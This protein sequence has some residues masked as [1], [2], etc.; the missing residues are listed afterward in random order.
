VT[1]L[2][3]QAVAR[4]LRLAG[5]AAALVLFATAAASAAGAEGGQ[6]APAREASTGSEASPEGEASL[7]GE[8]PPE[9]ETS[10]APKTPVEKQRAATVTHSQEEDPE[11]IGTPIFPQVQYRDAVR[12][13][14]QSHFV[15]P[16]D[17][18]SADIGV[19]GPDVRLRVTVPLSERGVLQ[20]TGRGGSSQYTFSGSTDWF[21]LG[22]TSSDPVDGLYSLVFALQGAYRLNDGGY[23][24][25]DGESWS[26]LGG[27]FGRSRWE[28]NNIADGWTGGGTVGFGYQSRRLRVALGASVESK[29]TSSGASVGPVA[30]IRW[31]PTKR[32]TLRNRGTGGQIEYRLSRPLK[33]FATGYVT[34]RR[35][36]LS[37][38]PGV[39]GDPTLRDRQ[40]L[41][42]VGFEWR[43]WRHLVLNLEGGVVA[44]HEIKIRSDGVTLSK[45]TAEPAGYFAIRIAV[46]P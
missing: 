35:Y 34:G 30:S 25:R 13:R 40:V 12:L 14:V 28:G 46:R 5:A 44:S 42:G 10:T 26:V 19:Y 43:P 15:P 16:S 1:L 37:D 6:N 32:I 29:L 7:E 8:A 39:Q 41:A 23:V 3:D 17:F 2:P 27:A 31:D 4:R 36:Q 21:G 20:F 38:R 9:D 22:S 33:L 11:N 18:G 24:F 45:T